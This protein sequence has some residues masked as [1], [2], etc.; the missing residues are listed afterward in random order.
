MRIENDG[1]NQKITLADHLIEVDRI[2]KECQ[3]EHHAEIAKLKEEFDEF[4]K[5]LPKPEVKPKAVSKKKKKT[6]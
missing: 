4:I 3:T 1:G 2:K 5:A 6:A